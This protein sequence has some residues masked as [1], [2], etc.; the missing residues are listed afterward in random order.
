MYVNG[1]SNDHLAQE[2]ARRN[3][4]RARRSTSRSKPGQLG[5]DHRHGLNDES[6]MRDVWLD[7]PFGKFSSLWFATRS[8]ESGDQR[9][10]SAVI[11]GRSPVPAAFAIPSTSTPRQRR[12]RRSATP[13]PAL[14]SNGRRCL[15]R[16]RSALEPEVCGIAISGG[17]RR[18]ASKGGITISVARERC[19]EPLSGRR[20]P[21]PQYPTSM[22]VR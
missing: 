12:L 18:R 22:I 3:R 21:H 6:S 4:R 16:W 13:S 10:V 11:A 9:A 7:V 15:S 17:C 20:Q 19:S 2:C 8:A 14:Q 1:G 5:R